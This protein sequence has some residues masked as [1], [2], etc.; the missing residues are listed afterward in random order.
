MSKKTEFRPVCFLYLEILRK[1]TYL[2]NQ[3]ISQNEEAYT[4]VGIY[5]GGSII[6]TVQMLY[7]LSRRGVP[8]KIGKH[9]NKV[10][11]ATHPFSTH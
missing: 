8:Q 2:E 5:L 10:K 6:W 1:R 3:F 4:W 9:Q 7:E 11:H